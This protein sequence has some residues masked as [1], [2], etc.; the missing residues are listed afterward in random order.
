MGVVMDV[1]LPQV[2]FLS[3][4]VRLVIVFHGRVVVL[5]RMSSRHVFPLSAVP[6]V[7]HD[8]SVLVSVND[9]IV[10][11]LHDLSLVTPL[12]VREPARGAWPG[13][14]GGSVGPARGSP[15]PA[16]GTGVPGGLAQPGGSMASS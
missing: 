6:Q 7:V 3:V 15:A 13:M 16:A 12:R 10:G 9:G 14:L 5:V 4:D 1:G 8:V 2:L 11:V